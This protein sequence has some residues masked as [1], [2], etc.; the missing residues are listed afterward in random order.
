VDRVY[1]TIDAAIEKFRTSP[2]QQGDLEFVIDHIARRSAKAV[3]GGYTWK[4]DSAIFGQIGGDLR[5]AAW[6]QLPKLTCSLALLRSEHGLVPAEIGREMVE[7]ARPGTFVVDLPLAGHHPMLDQ[8]LVLLT[9]IRSVLAG[10]E[11]APS[12]TAG[13]VSG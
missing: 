2:A 10:W 13:T 5:R 1:P 6:E 3:E 7:R 11:F 4:L 8:P 9:A 12:A